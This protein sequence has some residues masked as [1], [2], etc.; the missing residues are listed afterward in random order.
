MARI[1]TFAQ[2]MR[3]NGSSGYDPHAVTVDYTPGQGMASTSKGVGDQTIDYHGQPSGRVAAAVD[4]AVVQASGELQ[5]IHGELKNL[6][7]GIREKGLNRLAAVGQSFQGKKI[8]IYPTMDQGFRE[9][10]QKGI[11]QIQQS[12]QTMIGGIDDIG[13]ASAIIYPSAQGADEQHD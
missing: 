6:F 9:R 7:A 3:E 1:T 2:F 12:Q 4:P 10:L 8:S 13:R 5:S 11:S